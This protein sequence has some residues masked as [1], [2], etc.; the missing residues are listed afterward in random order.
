MFPRN[1]TAYKSFIKA[2]QKKLK[3]EKKNEKHILKRM[4]R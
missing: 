1:L 2:T 3:K 4:K